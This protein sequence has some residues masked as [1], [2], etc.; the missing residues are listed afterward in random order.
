MFSFPVIA[1]NQQKP[2][3]SLAS[4]VLSEEAALKYFGSEDPI[5]KAMTIQM[6][7]SNRVFVVSAI[8]DN[9]KDM[10]S[11]PFDFIIHID[12]VKDFSRPMI[13]PHIIQLL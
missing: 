7:D 6:A 8:A 4:M 9:M 10:S 1:G 12:N 2:L 11:I 5:G 13:L 3:P